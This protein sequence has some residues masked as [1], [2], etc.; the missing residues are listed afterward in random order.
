VALLILIFSGTD[1][2]AGWNWNFPFYFDD[3]AAS[4]ATNSPA[5]TPPTQTVLP[6]TQTDVS[7]SGTSVEDKSEDTPSTVQPAVSPVVSRGPD[8]AGSEDLLPAKQSVTVTAASRSLAKF[9]PAFTYR[10]DSIVEDSH[11]RG[12]VLLEG[13]ITV[14]PQATLFIHP[15]TV[16]RV[17]NGGGI[18][19][20]GRLALKGEKD[21]PI[22]ITSLYDESRPSDWQG[23]FFSGTD[24]NN[25]LENVRIEGGGTAINARF[26]SFSAKNISISNSAAGVQLQDG[27]ASLAEASFIGSGVGIAVSNS[28]LELDSV[29]FEGPGVGIV[30]T[31]SAL[32]ASDILIKGSS[33]TGLSAEESQLKIERLT[34]IGN[35]TGARL[36]KCEGSIS[37]SFFR[38]NRESGAVLTSSRIKMTGNLF[39]GNRIGLQLDDN[40]PAVWG[41]SFYNNKS[42]NL[43][44]LGE[45]KLFFGGNWFGTAGS[46]ELENTIFSKHTGS[47]LLDPLLTANPLI[48]Q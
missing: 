28:E 40:L 5:T 37:S 13:W 46:N 17:G 2:F 16:I 19:V 34:A 35:E 23:I 26:S 27:A 21:S 22:V 14:A 44:Y 20:Q 47:I 31:A 33:S 36:K 4:S 42:Y 11:W 41:S 6:E 38:N 25:S 29:S 43:L 15:G 24:K 12:L 48:V 39:T 9:T 18:L 10:S 30:A 3:S 45:G 32:I 7:N 8:G 1:L